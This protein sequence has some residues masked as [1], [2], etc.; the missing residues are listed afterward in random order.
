MIAITMRSSIRVNDGT[1]P[2]LF[3]AGIFAGFEDGFT[4][5]ILLLICAVIQ[6]TRIS[7]KKHRLNDSDRGLRGKY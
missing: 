1:L 3:P 5:T 7:R 4:W 2:G 6:Y